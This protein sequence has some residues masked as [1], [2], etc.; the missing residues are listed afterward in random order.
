MVL[1]CDV[2][3]L[4]LRLQTSN[5]LKTR[6]FMDSYSHTIYLFVGSPFLI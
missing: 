1:G 4:L 2:F 5:L 3:L 6:T